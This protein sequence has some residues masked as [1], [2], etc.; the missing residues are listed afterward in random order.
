MD[1]RLNAWPWLAHTKFEYAVMLRE[2]GRP[3]DR[4]RAETLLSSAAASA[5]R[6]GMPRLQQ[7]IR[8]LVR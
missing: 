3:Q 5:E 7:N 1:E 4:D 2:R 8:S 6:I